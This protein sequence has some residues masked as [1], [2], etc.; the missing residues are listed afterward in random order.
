MH[1]PTASYR[2]VWRLAAGL[3]C[4][5][6]VLDFFLD[7]QASQSQEPI[8]NV[9]NPSFPIYGSSNLL[10]TD[11][12][13]AVHVKTDQK[14]VNLRIKD[15]KAT[16]WP[17]GRFPNS[18]KVH[19]SSPRFYWLLCLPPSLLLSRSL[20]LVVFVLVFLSTSSAHETPYKTR[21]P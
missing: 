2:V 12:H 20:S 9:G 1:D 3:G 8:S 18:L 14:S 11:Y 5:F 16:Q 15:G 7:P 17:P 13:Q 10:L 6:L 21:E 4:C 19:G